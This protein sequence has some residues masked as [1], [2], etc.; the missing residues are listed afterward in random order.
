MCSQFYY[1]CPS[2][3]KRMRFP[4]QLKKMKKTLL[5]L[6][7]VTAILSADAQLSHLFSKKK[8]TDSTQIKPKPVPEPVVAKPKT[9]WSKI[10]LSK[11]PADH[12]VFQ[13][14]SDSWLNHPDS[15]KT[16]GFS[17]HFNFYV[18]MDKP[19]KTNPKFSFAYGL[20]LGSSNIFFD[21]EYVKVKGNGGTLAFDSTTHFHKSKV[22]TMY[23]EV[24]LEVRYYSDPQHPGKSW[25]AAV[26][27]KAGVLVKSYFK[28]KDLQ[29]QNGAS[30]YGS[31][32]IQKEF[33][34]RY[35]NGSTIVATARVGYG[36]FSLNCDYQITPVLK[37]GAG[38]D[39]HTLSIGLT[40]SGL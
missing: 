4:S 27:M 34:K 40:V 23:L 25:K 16:K 26:G 11:R 13:Y 3:K 39:M 37:Q 30:Y 5:L 8:K 1:F 22:T 29:D 20:G 6:L 7:C 35:F 24:P 2:F 12:F 31:T 32:Y 28:G 21:R 36:N 17:R 15:V 10:D 33:N 14:G 38:P 18:M 9:D 19:M